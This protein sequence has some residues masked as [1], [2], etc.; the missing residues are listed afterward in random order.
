MKCYIFCIL[1]GIL[2]Y[3][4]VNNINRFSIGGL[5]E[6]TLCELN[7]NTNQIC[8]IDGGD[9]NTCICVTGETGE[10]EYGLCYNVRNPLQR[11]DDY[12]NRDRG[13]FDTL[14]PSKK[15]L[16][17]NI[18]R[19]VTNGPRANE[20]FENSNILFYHIQVSENNIE[21]LAELGFPQEFIDRFVNVKNPDNSIWDELNTEQKDILGQIGWTRETW[22]S[23]DPGINTDPFDNIVT[24]EQIERYISNGFTLQDDF[25]NIKIPDN[26]TW[27]EL[28]T[29]QKDI[30]RQFGWTRDTW[31]R[32]D[33]N[34]YYRPPLGQRLRERLRNL[35]FSEKFINQFRPEGVCAVGGGGGEFV[36]GGGRGRAGSIELP[37]I[38]DIIL[39]CHPNYDDWIEA[40]VMNKVLQYIIV[41]FHLRS[42]ETK[43]YAVDI[44]NYSTDWINSFDR[45][46]YRCNN[47]ISD[48]R[49]AILN[50]G[51]YILLPKNGE[52]ILVCSQNRMGW[53]EAIV[54][55]VDFFKSNITAVG[56]GRS[57]TFRKINYGSDWIQIDD[58][59]KYICRYNP[60]FLSRRERALPPN[61]LSWNYLD[62]GKQ[63]FLNSLGFGEEEWNNPYDELF[64]KRLSESELSRLRAYGFEE[65]WISLFYIRIPEV[66][67]ESVSLLVCNDVD[68]DS[69]QIASNLIQYSRPS[70]NPEYA[71]LISEPFKRAISYT[72]RNLSE[73][74]PKPL[75]YTASRFF[76]TIAHILRNNDTSNLT[77]GED[78]GGSPDGNSDVQQNV[79]SCSLNL[80]NTAP[81]ESATDFYFHINNKAS[82]EIREMR[83]N[84][85]YY[86]DKIMAFVD[87]RYRNFVEEINRRYRSIF[88]TRVMFILKERTRNDIRIYTQEP[89]RIYLSGPFGCSV[90]GPEGGSRWK[91]S[92][93]GWIIDARR[94]G[95]DTD[96]VDPN[97]VLSKNEEI[98]NWKGD[99]TPEGVVYDTSKWEQ[100]RI[101]YNHELWE[102]EPFFTEEQQN[103]IDYIRLNKPTF[104]GGSSCN[105][106]IK[107]SGEVWT[108]G[109]NGCEWYAGDPDYR[110]SEYGHGRYVDYDLR[111][112]RGNANYY[113]CACGGGSNGNRDN[114]GNPGGEPTNTNY[115]LIPGSIGNNARWGSNR[116]PIPG[117]P[118]GGAYWQT[119][120][121]DFIEEEANSV[122]LTRDYFTG[123]WYQGY[124]GIP[125]GVILPPQ[126]PPRPSNTGVLCVDGLPCKY[127]N[128][129][130]GVVSFHHKLLE[131]L[132]R[133]DIYKK[134]IIIY[135]SSNGAATLFYCLNAI[136]YT[137]PELLQKIRTVVLFEPGFA[138][139]NPLF[140]TSPKASG[141]NQ[142][143]GLDK[144]VT[145]PDGEKYDIFNN[146]NLYLIQGNEDIGKIYS[147]LTFQGSRVQPSLTMKIDPVFLAYMIKGSTFE[148]NMQ[149]LD[150]NHRGD[151]YYLRRGRSIIP[152]TRVQV[153][154][155]WK[156]IFDQVKNN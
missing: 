91:P 119:V 103:A 137:N 127:R 120:I 90:M 82:K 104:V 47:A 58:R 113:C 95:K 26:C 114:G 78:I 56:G 144:F 111:L 8:N 149:S 87:V 123:N 49:E 94:L 23:L 116:Q 72:L 2:L 16:L 48:G 44:L 46:R 12:I 66:A 19:R 156:I 57:K 45:D 99:L 10:N 6:G 93:N 81:C 132:Q 7:E 36:G 61:R 102:V 50:E 141:Y 5:N 29:R 31:D 60:D 142:D 27:N 14:S 151:L 108:D 129:Y 134:S 124:P 15:M 21:M 65:S 106:L 38:G 131:L 43:Y 97:I 11:E 67:I 125:D 25:T 3:L 130:N 62:S 136:K 22:N 153:N 24:P 98:N 41:G 133:D 34:P 126:P 110:C 55:N 107:Q 147:S 121:E 77:L 76:Y 83:G 79:I 80:S 152:Y 86:I 59:D 35:N 64:N 69:C 117:A 109:R 88:D 155:A 115:I 74:N 101:A 146:I 40:R 140:Y 139:G 63:I 89:N 9:C 18:A 33:L 92:C 30:I 68:T 118:Y 105:D 1:I 100:V 96:I 150:S 52:R 122:N 71:L 145:L 37:N 20:Y 73:R 75:Y 135:A 143:T 39:I 70:L 28:N 13:Y 32:G 138:S 84:E 4:F 42:G 148:R 154:N 17:N 53:I 112:T 54:S 51:Q 85:N 128:G